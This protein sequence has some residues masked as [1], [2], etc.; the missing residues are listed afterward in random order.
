VFIGS[1]AWTWWR[2]ADRRADPALCVP[3]SEHPAE[4][5]W[6]CCRGRDVLLV[7][8]GPEDEAAVTEA[9]VRVAQ[10]GPRSLILAAESV[11]PTQNDG[12]LLA[13]PMVRLV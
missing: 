6:R 2:D 11:H 1:D 10:A 8:A 12:F 7:Q 4:F 13:L 5:D 9:A 3:P